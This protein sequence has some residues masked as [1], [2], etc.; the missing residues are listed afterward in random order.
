MLAAVRQNGSALRHAA[1]ALRNDREVVRA[2]VSRRWLSGCRRLRARAFAAAAAAAA[3]RLCKHHHITTS[4]QAISQATPR[5]RDPRRSPALL[6]VRSIRRPTSPALHCTATVTSISPRVRSRSSPTRSATR[7][8]AARRCR[9]EAASCPLSPLL[10][11]QFLLLCSLLGLFSS[12]CYLPLLLCPP[13]FLRSLLLHFLSPLLCLPTLF[14]LSLLLCCPQCLLLGLRSHNSQCSVLN[15]PSLMRCL[16]L[17]QAP[18]QNQTTSSSC[19][20]SASFAALSCSLSCS[21]S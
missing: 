2:A 4:H 16:L 15:H 17:S 21:A 8:Y 18:V 20:L 7:G 12:S 11:H 14:C 13:L 1:E 19:S 9:T 6:P 10:L 5:R 3:K